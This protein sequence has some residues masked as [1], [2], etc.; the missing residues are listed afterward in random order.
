MCRGL[1]D[2]P[3]TQGS[4]FRH[5]VPVTADVIPL[6][7]PAAPEEISKVMAFLI[8]DESSYVTGSTYLADAGLLC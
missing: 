3:M 1:V 5:N 2:T 7:R 8:S 4:V 6:R